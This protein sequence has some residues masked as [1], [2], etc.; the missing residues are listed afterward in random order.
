MSG[1]ILLAVGAVVALV[2]LWF[3]FNMSRITADKLERNPDGSLRD[4]APARR[5]GRIAMLAAP[6]CFLVFAALAFGWIPADGIDP[7]SFN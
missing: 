6:V 5:V 3:G 1:W 4:P 2:D 7:V